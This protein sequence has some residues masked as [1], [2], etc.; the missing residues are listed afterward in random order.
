MKKIHYG[1]LVVA[2]SCLIISMTAG[3]ITN[4]FSQFIKPVCADMGFSRQQMSMNQTIVSVT[5]MIFGL[6]WGA[7][8]K[9]IK[10]HHWMCGA[11]LLLPVCYFCYSFAPNLTVFYAV[12]VVLSVVFCFISMKEFSSMMIAFVS[13]ILSNFSLKKAE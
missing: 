9:R 13:E 4:S 10:L 11:A 7:I 1:W 2:A 3:V 8:S 5:G 6:F 12:T